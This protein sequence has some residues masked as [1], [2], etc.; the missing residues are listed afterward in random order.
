MLLIKFHEEK[1]FLGFLK[2]YMCEENA[3]ETLLVVH[4]YY[5]FY[6]NKYTYAVKRTVLF[7][8]RRARKGGVALPAYGDDVIMGLLRRG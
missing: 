4:I 2:N 8:E 5:L 1:S 7:I 3:F 6:R